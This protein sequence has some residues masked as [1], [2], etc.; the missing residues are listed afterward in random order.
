MGGVRS[1]RPEHMRDQANRFGVKTRSARVGA[2][3]ALLTVVSHPSVV[4]SQAAGGLS[5]A[6]RQGLLAVRDSVWR[7]F[8]AND[9]DR[10]RQLVPEDLIA[11]NPGDSAWQS[12]PELLAAAEDFARH[13]GRLI[14]LEFPKTE[15]Q[16]FG[17]AAVVYSRYVLRFEVDGAQRVVNGRA[18]EIFV[19]DRGRWRNPG[20]H[21]DAAQ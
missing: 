10:L 1:A 4:Y 17:S 13:N 15:V 12:R 18:T 19:Q 11:I 9:Q 20:W 8:Y 5:D 3:V 2:C 6:Q 7:A 21:L 16:A 14:S